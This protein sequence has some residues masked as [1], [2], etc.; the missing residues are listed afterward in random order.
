MELV[1]TCKIVAGVKREP[2][3]GGVRMLPFAKTA[4]IS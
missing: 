1:D 2:A 4:W 3:P